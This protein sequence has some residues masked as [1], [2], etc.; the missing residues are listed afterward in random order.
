MSNAYLDIARQG[1]NNWWRYLLGI[2]LITFFWLVIGSIVSAIFL[3]SPAITNGL[4]P[5]EFL[6]KPSIIGYLIINFQFIFFLL[7]IFLTM[8]WLHQRPFL[9]L[10]GA[11]A[12]IRWK[13]FF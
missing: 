7:G 11:D 6:R 4:N 2:I 12:I 5:L 10:V 9:S 3:F 1:K 13:R 8:K